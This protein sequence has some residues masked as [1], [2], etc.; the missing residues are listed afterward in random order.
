M[1]ICAFVIRVL[2]KYVPPVVAQ[3]ERGAGKREHG[4]FFKLRS[5]R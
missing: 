2:H 1:L 5:V 4:P 3:L